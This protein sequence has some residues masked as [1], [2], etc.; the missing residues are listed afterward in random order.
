MPDAPDADGHGDEADKDERH[1]DEDP[2]VSPG[3]QVVG[4][5]Q[6]EHKE[7]QVGGQRDE[8]GLVLH[9]LVGVHARLRP[10]PPHDGSDDCSGHGHG[11]PRPQRQ[12]DGPPRPRQHAVQLERQQ[13]REA[14][15]AAE[16]HE[17]GAVEVLEQ[18]AQVDISRAQTSAA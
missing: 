12:E 18:G 16:D 6:L 15:Q 17:A 2:Q 11:L 8:H 14:Q 13:Q 10:S 7:Q 4:H 5:E 3:L 9:V 1:E